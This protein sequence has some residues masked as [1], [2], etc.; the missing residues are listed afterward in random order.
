MHVIHKGSCLLLCLALSACG[1]KGDLYLAPVE[2][3]DEQKVLLEELN[4]K[5]TKKKK[6]ETSESA[7]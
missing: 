3:T 7:L 4:S 5:K 6:S 1:N 2:L